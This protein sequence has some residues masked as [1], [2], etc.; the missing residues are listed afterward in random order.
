[1]VAVDGDYEMYLEWYIISRAPD[2]EPSPNWSD[3]EH[4]PIWL[5]AE[6]NLLTRG[7]TG[8]VPGQEI[9]QTLDFYEVNDERTFA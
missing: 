9:R 5:L 8:F 6:L 2:Q 7:G 1:M 4:C 3:N